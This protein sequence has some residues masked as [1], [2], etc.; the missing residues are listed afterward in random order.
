MD[1]PIDK[2]SAFK[3]IEL[4]N[5]KWPNKV[6][7]KS[8]IWCSVDLRDGNQALIE[9]MG[10]ERKDRMFGLLCK[11]GFKEI[12]VGFPSASQTDFNF[13]RDLIENKKIPSDVNIQVLTQ[14]REEL[15]VKT[16]ESLKGSPKAII[17]FY[18]STSTLQRKVVF[19]Q[20]KKGIKKIA[21]DA[22]LLIKNLAEKNS[23]TEWSF[24]YSP[25]SFTGTEL[26]YAREVCDEVVEILKPVSK[27]KIIINLPATVEMSTPNIYG[28]QIEW[29]HEN[30]QNRKDICLS[31]HPHNDRGTAVAASEFGLMAGADRVE[32]T[33]F[34]NGERTGNVDVVTI[35]LNMLTQGIDPKL[36][37]S[38]INSVMREVEYCNQLPV[39]PR[40]PYAGDLVFTAFSGSHQDAIKKGFQSIKR[41]NEPKWEVPYLPIDPADLGRSYE[42]VV[43]INSQS[44]KGGVAFLLEKD[45]G[46]SLPR[47]LQISLS[48]KI[49]KLADET[50]KEIISSQI[51]EIFE[52]NYLIPKNNFSYIKHSSSSKDD[53]HSLDLTL[54]MDNKEITIQG[55]GNGPIDSFINGLSNNIGVNIKVADYHQSAISSGSDAQAAAYIELEKDGDTFWGVGIHPN[56]TRASFDSIIVGLSKLLDS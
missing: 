6:I 43:R 27:N 8:P 36:D 24:E 13:V 41:S 33:L 46:V 31:L 9:P 40:H 47:R 28:D 39:H 2:Y 19:D 44:G 51:W 37:F 42:A 48:Q 17:H 16:F 53:I 3:P 14:A 4:D 10:S 20:N 26:E 1:N 7:K 38:N 5:R 25:E 35:A 23:E 56:T 30:L 50:G 55:T 18:N 45:H 12:E 32:G 11:L 22:A 15:I 34:G 21:T 54:N 49:Q 52:E 29:M